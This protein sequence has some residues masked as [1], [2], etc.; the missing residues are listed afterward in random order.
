MSY[1]NIMAALTSLPTV[2]QRYLAEGHMVKPEGIGT[3]YLS[4]Q[5]SK[6]GIEKKEL[7]SAEQITNVKVEFLMRE[8]ALVCK[9]HKAL[10]RYPTKN[11]APLWKKHLGALT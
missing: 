2:M 11:N 7:C 6:T 9:A 1:T 4:V 8:N 10:S 5:C 3:F